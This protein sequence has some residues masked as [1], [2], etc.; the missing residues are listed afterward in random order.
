MGYMDRFRK[1]NTMSHGNG[2]KPPIPFPA[3]AAAG[4]PIL[5]LPFT[6][7]GWF[8]QILITCKC[9]TPKPVLLIGQPGSA[10][11]LCPACK[12]GYLLQTI[13]IDPRTGKPHFQIAMVT[14]PAADDATKE[15]Q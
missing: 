13:G 11:G 4:I 10:G 8:I 1:A 7:E 3:A 6:L 5:G 9:E 2:D 14:A 12:Q 15:E